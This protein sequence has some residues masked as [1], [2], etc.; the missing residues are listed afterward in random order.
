[1]E[2][3]VMLAPPDCHKTQQTFHNPKTG[4]VFGSYDSYYFRL[5]I[6]NTG[7]LR[8][9]RVQVFAAGRIAAPTG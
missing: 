7:S 4:E 5:W 6:R 3:R 1:M 9:E 2:L 8:A